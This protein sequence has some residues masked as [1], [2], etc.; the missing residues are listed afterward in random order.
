M[1]KIIII[2]SLI[3]CGFASVDLYTDDYF[4]RKYQMVNKD[5]KEIKERANLPQKATN[6]PGNNPVVNATESLPFVETKE[7]KKNKK[8]TTRKS[9]IVRT[10]DYSKAPSK[11]D[12]IRDMQNKTYYNPSKN[13]FYI[14]DTKY[15]ILPQDFKN[16]DVAFIGVNAESNNINFELTDNSVINGKLQAKNGELD[17]D[18]FYTPKTKQVTTLA[19]NETP[20]AMVECNFVLPNGIRTALNENNE[21]IHIPQAYKNQVVKLYYEKY[22]DFAYVSNSGFAKIKISKENFDNNCKVVK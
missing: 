17:D 8:K 18:F 15:E 7:I 20:Q 9:P 13:V 10:P 1:K 2:L 16:C 11:C 19:K 14:G 6:K 3:S 4:F 21:I 22:S 5:K 12:I